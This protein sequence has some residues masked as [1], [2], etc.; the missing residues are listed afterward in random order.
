MEVVKKYERCVWC[1]KSMQPVGHA[2]LNGARHDDW[3]E[4]STHKQCWIENELKRKKKR[5]EGTY[6]RVMHLDL[7][8]ET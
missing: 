6:K 3:D 4:R 8:T 1:K 2:R 5:P 7:E